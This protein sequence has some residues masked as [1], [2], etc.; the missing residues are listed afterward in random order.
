MID[1]HSWYQSYELEEV[2]FG[3]LSGIQEFDFVR[4]M[5]NVKWICK[6]D[7]FIIKVILETPL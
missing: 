4:D 7:F 2:L 1:E 6:M 5:S 3:V